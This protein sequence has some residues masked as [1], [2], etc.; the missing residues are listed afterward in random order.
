MRISAMV[1]RASI[2]LARSI[3]TTKQADAAVLG[4]IF[5][6]AVAASLRQG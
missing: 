4:T 6:A 3:A 2:R 1:L 5:L